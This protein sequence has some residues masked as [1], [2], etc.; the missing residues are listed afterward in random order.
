M[1]RTVTTLHKPL[2]QSS[3]A[4]LQATLGGN[5]AILA[6]SLHIKAEEKQEEQGQD[7]PAKNEKNGKDMNKWWNRLSVTK[8]HM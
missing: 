8:V 3:I 1:K 6:D 4:L 2:D 7:D 5:Y